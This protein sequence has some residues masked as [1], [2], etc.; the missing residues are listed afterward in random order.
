[1]SSIALGAVRQPLPVGLLPAGG[2]VAD[3]RKAVAQLNVGSGSASSGTAAAA[4]APSVASASTA[5]LAEL[6]SGKVMPDWPLVPCKTCEQ[7]THWKN[8]KQETVWVDNLCDESDSEGESVVMY[9]CVKCVAKEMGVE[10]NVALAHI[11]S[12]RKDLQKR[13]DR[14]AAYK[15]AKANPPATWEFEHGNRKQRRVILRNE[16]LDV[17]RPAAHAILLKASQLQKRAGH[18]EKHAALCER[19]RLEKNPF[20]MEKILGEIDEAEDA[21]CNACEPL[22]FQDRSRT[23]EELFRYRMAADYSDGWVEVKAADGRLLG[24][25]SSFYICRAGAVESKCNSLILNKDWQRQHVDILAPGQRWKCRC[26]GTKYLTK[27]GMIVE[28]RWVGGGASLS[29]APC[30]DDDDKDLHACILQDKFPD[31]K[32][33]EELYDLIP[34]VVPQESAFLRKAVQ[35]D[36]WGGEYQDHGVYKLEHFEVLQSLPLWNWKDVPNFF[37]EHDL[38][39]KKLRVQDGEVVEC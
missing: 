12:T 39:E 21:F 32:T 26:C 16:M 23:R 22:A 8:S 11:R 18:G 5:A 35:A 15:K 24:G 20:E 29:L 25:F 10:E 38:L 3:L 2:G 31:V 1:M 28:I 4:A 36:F 6:P 34:T 14:T 9:W 17:W 37:S 33:A 13:M 19:L 7:L 27:F 30:T